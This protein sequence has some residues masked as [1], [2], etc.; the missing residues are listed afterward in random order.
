MAWVSDE[1][2]FT[3]TTL[4]VRTHSREFQ[5]SERYSKAKR[6]FKDAENA[7]IAWRAYGALWTLLCDVTQQHLHLTKRWKKKSELPYFNNTF[8]EN[9]LTKETQKKKIHR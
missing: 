8:T 4:D 5:E 1:P 2:L 7:T 3:Q 9:V 6:H